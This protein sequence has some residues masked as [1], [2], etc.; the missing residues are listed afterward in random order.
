MKNLKRN[1]QKMENLL[2]SGKKMSENFT[3]LSQNLLKSLKNVAKL[4]I[5]NGKL[6]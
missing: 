3:Y 4:N 1:R 2:I 6:C 5:N